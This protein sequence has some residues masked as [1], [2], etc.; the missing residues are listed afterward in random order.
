MDP[1]MKSNIAKIKA[2]EDKYGLELFWMSA[3]HL[4]DV[5][6]N[7]MRDKSAVDKEISTIMEQ[8]KADSKN[9]K[10]TV[11]TPNFKRAILECAAELAMF[12]PL[13]VFTYVTT[14]LVISNYLDE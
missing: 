8:D 4:F 12:T 1:N 14:H 6:M 10:I 11:M 3:I 5:G 13:T 2:L 7:V 9:G